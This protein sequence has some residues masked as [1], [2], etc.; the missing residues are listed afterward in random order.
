[1]YKILFTKT[2]DSIFRESRMFCKFI[3]KFWVSK[4][5]T[6]PTV[7]P[8]VVACVPSVIGDVSPVEK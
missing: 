1:M 6:V 2:T 4:L 7:I 5:T 8:V 3:E